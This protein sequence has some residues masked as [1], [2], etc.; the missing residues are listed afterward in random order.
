MLF[1]VNAVENEKHKSRENPKRERKNTGQNFYT[2]LRYT[3]NDEDKRTSNAERASFAKMK[4]KESIRKTRKND[5]CVKQEQTAK[6]MY[7]GR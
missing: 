3:R 5:K 1:L 4:K 2:L 6:E 7:K